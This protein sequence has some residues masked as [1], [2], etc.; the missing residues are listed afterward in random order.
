[1]TT[2][3]SSRNHRELT[4]VLLRCA[5]AGALV[6]VF[7]DEAQETVAALPSHRATKRAIKATCVVSDREDLCYPSGV[8]ELH[9]LGLLHC[10]R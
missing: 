10:D 8:F 6:C 9:R 2:Y 3:I 7:I 4:R 5:R 1:M